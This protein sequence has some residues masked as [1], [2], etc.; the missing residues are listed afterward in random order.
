MTP[1]EH[2]LKE[3]KPQ[4]SSFTHNAGMISSEWL[5][6]IM[7]EYIYCRNQM[8]DWRR[9]LLFPVIEV[10]FVIWCWAIMMTFATLHNTANDD[11]NNT[12]YF[13]HEDTKKNTKWTLKI[14]PTIFQQLDNM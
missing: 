10:V 11:S 7:Y 14:L 3:E 12:V 9:R 5:H 2:S 4:L 8:L 1:A 6:Y 13:H